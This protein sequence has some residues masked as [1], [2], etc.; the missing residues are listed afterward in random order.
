M[1]NELL[2]IFRNTPFGRETL[3]SSVYFSKKTGSSLRVYIPKF[4]QFLMYFEHE[5]VTVDLDR[6]FLRDPGTAKQHAE[7]IIVHGGLTPHFI[8]PKGFTASTLPDLP[9]DF[10]YMTCPRTIANLSTKIGLG[11]IGP[12]VRALI[13]NAS[14]PIY[15][16]TPVY[17]EWKSV[18]IFFGG[19]ENAIKALQYGI[20]ISTISGFPLFI[21]TQGEG[22]ELRYY[23][24]EIKKAGLFEKLENLGYE[25]LFFDRGQLKINL[26][27]V[28]HDALAIVGAYGHG[29]IREV[30]FG[31]KMEEIQS[32]IP[33]DLLIVGPKCTPV[34]G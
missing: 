23:E 29:V 30:L 15:I 21:F 9:V 28:P 13:R 25:W 17:K 26:Y 4:H 5:V 11:Y 27:E 2:H 33:N 16:P 22:Q 18:V 32:V 12:R 7:E 6:A 10:R 3:M 34:I 31:S 14:F 8:E 20:E 19:S 24:D 1:K